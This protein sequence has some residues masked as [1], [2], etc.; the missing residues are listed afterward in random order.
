MKFPYF[1]V[2]SGMRK[3]CH[4]TNF[5][6]CPTSHQNQTRISIWRYLDTMLH[7]LQTFCG[8][9]QMF[10]R[11]TITFLWAPQIGCHYIYRTKQETLQ[12]LILLPLSVNVLLM[13]H[14]LPLD[15][16]GAVMSK[17][18]LVGYSQGSPLFSRFMPVK[19]KHT[20]GQHHKVTTPKQRHIRQCHD[21]LK[22]PALK[23][24][25]HWEQR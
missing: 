9:P 20:N 6:Q 12:N 3:L 8:I 24:A 7:F 18:S 23:A 1:S 13:P 22:S 25:G 14:S 19:L 15:W 5:S 21:E 11:G 10:Y 4:A 16:C 17:C 2:L